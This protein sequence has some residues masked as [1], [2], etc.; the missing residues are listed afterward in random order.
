MC[1]KYNLRTMTMQT[2]DADGFIYI[3]AAVFHISEL[4]VS[5]LSATYS[6]YI[7]VSNDMPTHAVAVANDAVSSDDRMTS[8]RNDGQSQN[9]RPVTCSTQAQQPVNVPS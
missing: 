9:S 5:C 4:N 1:G 3:G 6:Y 2:D 7:N 8:W